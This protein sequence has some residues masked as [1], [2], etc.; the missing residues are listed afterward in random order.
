MILTVT[1]N[2]CVDLILFV[3]GLAAHDTNRVQSQEED[4]GGKGV[5]VSRVACELGAA[6][7]ATG[8]L[9]GG[10]GAHV[11]HVLKKQGVVCDFVAI[12]GETR[13][14][15]SVESGGGRPPTTFNMKGPTIRH[16]E[17]DE[18]LAKVSALAAPG[19][20]VCLGGSLP[21]G[22][23]PDAWKVIGG[24][25]KA[26][27]AKVVLDADGDVMREGMKAAPDMIKPNLREAERLLGRTI[28]GRQQAGEAA[29]A[30]FEQL[31]GEGAQSPIV[32][33]SMGAQGAVMATGFGLHA[34]SAVKIEPRSTIGSGDSMIG[35][36][37]SGMERGL[38]LEQCLALGAA[39]GA[40]TALTDGT[41]IARR[42]TVERLLA[43]VVVS[44][45]G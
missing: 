7:T 18:L 3:D 45:L 44:R 42:P 34:C 30:L 37:L 16:P 13:L 33:L 23:E 8:F 6:S 35:G 40:A 25:A 39:A 10:Q 15:V 28:E 38:G 41:E 43:D 17:W 9:G 11:R 29:R 2:P 1:P 22:L 27:G 4:A 36:F 31:Q 32:L 20:W 12:S 21:P 14:N 24:I 5:N 26:R 19:V